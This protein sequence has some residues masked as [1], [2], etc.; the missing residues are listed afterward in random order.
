MLDVPCP[1]ICGAVLWL[2]AV[3]DIT[4]IMTMR[5]G[6]LPAGAW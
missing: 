5:Y 1:A 2:T 4:L 3:L 6:A